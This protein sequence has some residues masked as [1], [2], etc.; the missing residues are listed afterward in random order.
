MK[1]LNDY[2]NIAY[3]F[4]IIEDKEEG[5]FTGYYPELSGCITCADTIE[6]LIVIAEDAK[7]EWI[8][9]SIKD[10]ITIPEPPNYSGQFKLRVPKTLHKHLAEKAEMEGVSMNQYCVSILSKYA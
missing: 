9:N 8:E 5:G 2:M 6:E 1:T 4:V 10:G 7:R 3:K